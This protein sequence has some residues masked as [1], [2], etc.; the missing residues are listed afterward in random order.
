MNRACSSSRRLDQLWSERTGRVYHQVGVYAG[1]VLRGEKAAE[2]PVTQPTK[3]DLVINLTA[4]KALGITV[5]QT[6]LVAADEVIE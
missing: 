4:A 2:L 3:F 1:K 6:L 5:P